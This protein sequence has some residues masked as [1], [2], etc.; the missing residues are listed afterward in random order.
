MKTRREVIDAICSKHDAAVTRTW[1]AYEAGQITLDEAIDRVGVAFERSD[2]DLKR[3][4]I[5]LAGQK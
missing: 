3:S 4:G 5:E 2:A 1:D